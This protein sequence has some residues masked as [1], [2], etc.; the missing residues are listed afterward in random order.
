[1]PRYSFKYILTDL[2]KINLPSTL[3]GI[4]FNDDVISIL[5]VEM[6]NTSSK[7]AIKKCLLLRENKNF[8]I[9]IKIFFDSILLDISYINYNILNIND[10]NLLINQ[11]AKVQFCRN[12]LK[13]NVGDNCKIFGL[14]F[15]DVCENCSNHL[16]SIIQEEATILQ[17][18]NAKK[19][20]KSHPGIGNSYTC[21]KCLEN[22]TSLSAIK[23]HAYVFH[24][25]SLPYKSETNNSAIND[26]DKSTLPLKNEN[27]A[28][29]KLECTLCGS[30]FIDRVDL[31]NHELLHLYGSTQ[32]Q[33][34]CS[35]CKKSCDLLDTI[36]KHYKKFHPA[37]AYI[38]C[39]LCSKCFTGGQQLRVHSR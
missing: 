38:K 32:H 15:T 14:N 9:E 28:K 6:C 20:E 36:I 31:K 24:N 3:W 35:V 4:H 33:F 17:S 34:Q 23:C 10:L 26:D 27:S 8:N 7:I 2:P 19:S 1:M 37:V 12:Y 13:S 5:L 39:L 22:C 29:K 25:G 18:R 30:T 11:V 21:T 16:Y